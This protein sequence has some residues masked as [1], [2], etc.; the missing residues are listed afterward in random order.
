[1]GWVLFCVCACTSVCVRACL[2]VCMRAL[3]RVV[4]GCGAG[5]E[6]AM[7]VGNF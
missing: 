4:C 3:S 7:V 2:C 1:M 5:P 6:P